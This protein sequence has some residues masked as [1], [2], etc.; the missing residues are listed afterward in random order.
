MFPR[1]LFGTERAIK[2]FQL[3]VHPI[4]EDPAEQ[5][6]CTAWGSVFL[7]GGCRLQEPDRR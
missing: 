3:E 2:D 7:Y 1:T 5:E 4:A 6:H